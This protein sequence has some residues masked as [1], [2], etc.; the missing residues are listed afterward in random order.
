M[1]TVAKQEGILVFVVR[2]GRRKNL[3]RALRTL[4]GIDPSAGG[5]F[6]GQQS[7]DGRPQRADAA[8]VSRVRACC[9]LPP[10][11]HHGI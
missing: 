5:V 4:L 10:C 3:V 8:V 1:R 6:G 11:I 7:D 9:V 2:N